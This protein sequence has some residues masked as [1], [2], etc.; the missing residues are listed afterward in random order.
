[1]KI[2]VVILLFSTNFIYLTLCQYYGLS[3]TNECPEEC[4]CFLLNVLTDCSSRN[5]TELPT[6]IS[7][8]VCIVLFT[9]YNLYLL[10]M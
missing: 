5:L 9:Y 4:E 2:P 8:E 1:M 10:V 7:K 3:G 6:P